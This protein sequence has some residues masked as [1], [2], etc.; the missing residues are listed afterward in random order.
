MSKDEKKGPQ[1]I[2]D[3]TADPMNARKHNPRNIGM[4]VDSLQELGAARSIV[5]DED[6]VVLAG[7]GVVEAAGE[8]GITKL[9]VV[10]AAGDELVAVRRTGLTPE[11]KVDLALRDNRAAELSEWEPEVLKALDSKM[12]ISHLFTN[13]EKD[14]L[15]GD[16]DEGNGTVEKVEIKRAHEVVWMLLAIPVSEWPK[17]QP[18][19]EKLQM[20]AKTTAQIIR[21]AKAEGK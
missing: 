20:V 15:F 12:D 16:D 2:A 7:N 21:P 17:Y 14:K 9:K 10:D 5:I 3:L 19:V 1:T 13:A 6:G 8:A 11:Q 18:E 4:I